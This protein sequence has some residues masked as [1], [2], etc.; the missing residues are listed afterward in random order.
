MRCRTTTIAVALFLML[1]ITVSIVT[2]PNANAQESYKT[3]PFIG[4]TP[5]PVGVNQEVLFHVGITQPLL[6]QEMGWEGLSITIEGPDG[7]TETISGIKTD[8]TG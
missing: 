8:S 2:L 7:T 6:S 1:A 3:Y 5:N 4:A